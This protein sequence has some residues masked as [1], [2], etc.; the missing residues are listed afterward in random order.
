MSAARFLPN[1]GQEA[2][3]PRS[4]SSAVKWIAAAP[5]EGWCAC[6]LGQST[7]NAYSSTTS[8]LF[9]FFKT[10][11]PP[12]Y[13]LRGRNGRVRTRPAP[14]SRKHRRVL[15]ICVE[16]CACAHLVWDGMWA[17]CGRGHL[18][19]QVSPPSHFLHTPTSCP[20]IVHPSLQT[21]PSGEDALA[22]CVACPSPREGAAP[23][24]PR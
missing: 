5:T 2:P 1:V 23:Q 9:P 19:L 3:R 22:V 24:K 17:G 4:V 8:L 13:G 18:A 12:P 10:A 7:W 11:A 14:S 21:P 6:E 16:L 20:T 15:V